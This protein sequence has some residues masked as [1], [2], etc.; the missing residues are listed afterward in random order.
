MKMACR[1]EWLLK[2]HFIVY[3]IAGLTLTTQM[4]FGVGM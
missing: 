2:Y 4:K 1:W 3:E